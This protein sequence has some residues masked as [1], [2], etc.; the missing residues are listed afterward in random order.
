MLFL[1]QANLTDYYQYAVDN[2]TVILNAPGANVWLV[3]DPEDTDADNYVGE[4]WE[5]LNGNGV[6]D[7]GEEWTDLGTP[8]WDSGSSDTE[9]CENFNQMWLN[10]NE[11]CT[12]DCEDW[13]YMDLALISYDCTECLN[14][15]DCEEYW[16]DEWEENGPGCI[17]GCDG[18]HLIDM[19]A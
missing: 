11:T 16:E 14:N 5:D 7:E 3:C 9:W 6:W 1:N 13:E 18:Y 2:G 4:C 8:I 12:D 10:E 15:Y 17:G 19:D